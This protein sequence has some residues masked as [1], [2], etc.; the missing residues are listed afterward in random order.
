MTIVVTENCGV[1]SGGNKRSPRTG[2]L[3]HS[4]D[5]PNMLIRVEGKSTYKEWMDKKMIIH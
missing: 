5:G 1:A 4:N 3:L 2:P